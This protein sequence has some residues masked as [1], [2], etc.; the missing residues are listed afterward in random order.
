VDNFEELQ[1]IG[2]ALGR[3]IELADLGPFV[4]G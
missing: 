2:A 1:R 3:R 4:G